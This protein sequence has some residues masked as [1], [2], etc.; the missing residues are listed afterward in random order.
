MFCIKYYD[1]G[2]FGYEN[3]P[4]S[5]KEK[6]DNDVEAIKALDEAVLDVNFD[7][8]KNQVEALQNLSNRRQPVNEERKALEIYAGTLPDLQKEEEEPA[9]RGEY[10]DAYFSDREQKI[11]NPV[12]AVGEPEQDDTYYLVSDLDF[13]TGTEI[14]EEN[15][16]EVLDVKEETR[17]WFSWFQERR[18]TEAPS[19]EIA[20]A[21][22]E[23]VL[24]A[25]RP[26]SKIR[27]YSMIGV[28]S[29]VALVLIGLVVI[30]EPWVP[31]PVDAYEEPQPVALGAPVTLEVGQSYTLDVSCGENEEVHEIYSE[32]NDIISVLD[33]NVQ[34][35][36]EWD[37]VKVY[38]KTME[39]EVPD[40][41]LKEFKLFGKD[42]TKPY[43]DLRS[44]LRAFF[45]VETKK[46]PRTEKRVVSIY[47]QEFHV[48]GYETVAV[49]API[50]LYTQDYY[51]MT[52]LH[53]DYE[54]V[55]FTYE[56]AIIEVEKT[57]P[58]EDGH[59]TYLAKSADIT[60]KGK[61][62]ATTG[63]YKDN[64]FVA[65]GAMTFDVEVLSRP[66]TGEEVVFTS[67]RYNGNIMIEQSEGGSGQ[68]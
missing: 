56:G 4:D 3:K 61:I 9:S 41:H 54:E 11:S 62:I 25:P 35:H 36:G 23:E 47:E 67:G 2:P 24:A 59:I 64:I 48:S 18:N 19:K 26:T 60:G 6:T 66:S 16:P 31:A 28:L 32:E 68:S 34:A 7:A 52:I 50:N 29:V 43:N 14:T 46:P 44:N 27:K 38:V 5:G 58:N 15:A 51:E 39:K 57:I 40:P 33:N 42:L 49:T 1:Y 12:S 55:V 45:G 53:A 13:V 17:T 22:T 65:T 10:W 30:A 63:F 8:I 37:S 21:T 20:E